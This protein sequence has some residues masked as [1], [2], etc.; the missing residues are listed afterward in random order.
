MPPQS[1]WWPSSGPCI[2]LLI[3]EW[4]WATPSC[5]FAK[6]CRHF[7]CCK[8]GSQGCWKSCQ[9]Q[10]LDWNHHLLLWMP[11]DLEVSFSVLYG[12]QYISQPICWIVSQNENLDSLKSV[13]AW[14]GRNSWLVCCHCINNPLLCPYGQCQCTSFGKLPAPETNILPQKLHHHSGF[15]LKPGV[16]NR[17]WNVRQVRLMLADTFTKPLV[18]VVSERL[19][20]L[21]MGW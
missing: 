19:Q 11:L 10:D 12:H 18:R 3:K 13:A 6:V 21:I 15:H 2:G 5:W 16:I 20:L 14:N 9:C 4:S 17:W 8:L 1:S 7:L